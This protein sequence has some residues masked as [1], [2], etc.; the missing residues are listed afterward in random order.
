MRKHVC[1]RL[2]CAKKEI[3]LRRHQGEEVLLRVFGPGNPEMTGKQ[4]PANACGEYPRQVPDGVQL[5]GG[6]IRT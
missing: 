1:Q 5:V 2:V 6:G 3:R 4:T